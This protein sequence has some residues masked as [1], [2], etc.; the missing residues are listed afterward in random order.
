MRRT[1]LSMS[2]LALSACT[3][4]P[5]PDGGASMDA[6]TLRDAGAGRDASALDASTPADGGPSC[7]AAQ[8]LCDGVCTS[9]MA[10]DPANGCR[11]G[12]GD[13]CPSADAICNADGTCGIRGC[14][15]MTCEELAVECGT[16]DDGCGSRIGCGTCSGGLRCEAGMCVCDGDPLEANDTAASATTLTTLTDQPD[17]IVSVTT[18]TVHRSGDVDW[19]RA[20]VENNCCGGDPVIEVT[21]TGLPAG[22]DYDLGVFYQCPDGNTPTCTMGMAD[23]SVADGGCVSA[24]VGP[25]TVSFATNCDPDGVVFVRVQPFRWAGSCAPYRVDIAVR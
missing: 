15:P 11:L 22:E 18:A 20:T 1:L 12:C 17:S 23:A 14:T 19:F 21:L 6:G 10:N 13:P 3:A 24:A 25:D 5:I 2:L 16:T 4:Q 9:P 8:H 7:G